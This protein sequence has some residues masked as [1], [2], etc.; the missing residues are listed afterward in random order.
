MVMVVWTLIMFVQLVETEGNVR[1]L[2]DQ[3]GA[4]KKEV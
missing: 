4:L 3:M 2:E 1:D